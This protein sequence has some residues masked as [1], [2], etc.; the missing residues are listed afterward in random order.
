M[1]LCSW[2]AELR[3][4]TRRR[5]AWPP[6][7]DVGGIVGGGSRSRADARGRSPRSAPS[8][9]SELPSQPGERDVRALPGRRRRPRPRRRSRWR[10][11]GARARRRPV[12]AA[13]ACPASRSRSGRAD[14]GVVAVA[15]ELNVSPCGTRSLPRGRIEDQGAGGG[16]MPSRA[17][18]AA[19][20]TEPVLCLLAASKR[21]RWPGKTPSTSNAGC[22]VPSA[23]A[24]QCP[25]PPQ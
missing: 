24:A 11:P 10:R 14:A 23:P 1:A 16:W 19:P 8:A 5:R 20:Q 25:H 2:S 12:R 7:R 18:G 4:W 17:E 22:L 21:P 13:R 9:C 15:H 3:R 6:G